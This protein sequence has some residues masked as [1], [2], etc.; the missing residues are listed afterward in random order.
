MS[1]VL[2]N[3]DKNSE[4]I[5]ELPELLIIEELN[6]SLKEVNTLINIKRKT[7][8]ILKHQY[9]F[10]FDRPLKSNGRFHAEI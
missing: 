5:V 1:I 10:L 4:I 9:S 7:L 8:K 2:E 3:I 6:L